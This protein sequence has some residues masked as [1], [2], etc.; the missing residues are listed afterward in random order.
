[1]CRHIVNLILLQFARKQISRR[2][3]LD[4]KPVD[5]SILFKFMQYKL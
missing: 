4:L 1:M 3:P 5:L 2:F